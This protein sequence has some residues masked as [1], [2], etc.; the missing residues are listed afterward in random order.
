MYFIM[1]FFILVFFFIIGQVF[2]KHDN[3]KNFVWGTF[4]LT[5]ILLLILILN[6]V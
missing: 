1:L 6:N 4:G 3:A 5:G 2:P